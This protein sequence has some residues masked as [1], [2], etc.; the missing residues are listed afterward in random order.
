MPFRARGIHVSLAAAAA[1][2]CLTS[3]AGAEAIAPTSPP[4]QVVERLHSAL[5]GVMKE[6]EK[7]GYQGRYEKLAPVL[8]ETYDT[9]FMA[10]KS[11]GRHWKQATPAQQKTLVE[12]F[13]RFMIANYAGRFDG[14][15][16]QSF[17]T[18]KVEPSAQGTVLVRTRLIEPEGEGVRLDYRLR[19]ANGSWRIIDVYLNGTVSELA[20]RRSEYASLI[21]REGWN[22]VIVALDDRIQG[23]ATAPADQNL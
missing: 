23:F 13:S 22:A 7:L 8:K 19:S 14:Y 11:V 18:V 9:S 3:P 5:L 4:I 2:L 16:G 20:L 10:E 21:K 12:T 15:S 1:A 6:A 17:Q